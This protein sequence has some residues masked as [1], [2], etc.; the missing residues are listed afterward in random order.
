Q[1]K[2]LP[3][4]LPQGV[5][6]HHNAAGRMLSELDAVIERDNVRA[7]SVPGD[8]EFLQF[9]REAE[10]V[11]QP[12]THDGGFRARLE[13]EATKPAEILERLVDDRQ[14]DDGVDQVRIDVQTAEDSEQQ[15]RAVPDR[16][17]RDVERDVLQA[18]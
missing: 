3:Q 5:A 16:E 10:A 14:A 1:M 9:R 18:V 13:T 11:K 15:R 4:A 12:E 7:E 8:R 6:D 2:A 17:Q